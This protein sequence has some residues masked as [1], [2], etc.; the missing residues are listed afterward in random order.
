MVSTLAG[1]ISDRLH[2]LKMWPVVSSIQHISTKKN[3]MHLNL[4]LPVY[5]GLNPIYLSVLYVLK[6]DRG[7]MPETL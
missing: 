1:D 5:T 7:V 4:T 6:K 2:Q 3:L